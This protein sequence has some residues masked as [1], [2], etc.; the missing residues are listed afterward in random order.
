MK[1]TLHFFS[2]LSSRKFEVKPKVSSKEKR[3]TKYKFTKVFTEYRICFF[4]CLLILF[5]SWE[6]SDLYIGVFWK[7]VLATSM[8]MKPDEHER[9]TWVFYVI[10]FVIE[11]PR[12]RT[13]GTFENPKHCPVLSN[14]ILLSFKQ[15]RWA[16]PIPNVNCS[17]PRSSTAA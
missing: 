4:V 11:L 2:Y 16:V 5:M 8:R 12:E 9:Y 10:F 7:F 3:I 13:V 17:V 14:I 15:L 6:T 1:I